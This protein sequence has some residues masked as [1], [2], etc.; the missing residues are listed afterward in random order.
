MT[1]KEYKDNR[2]SEFNKLPIFFAYSDEQ[3]ARA[4][5]ARGLTAADTDQVY[6]CGQAL[7]LKKDAEAVRA[8]LKRDLDAELREMMKSDPAFAEDAFYYEMGN[9]EYFINWQ[10]SW[11]V[12]SCFGSVEYGDGKG[13]RDYLAELGF[14][15]EVM[16]AYECAKTKLWKYWEEHDMF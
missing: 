15:E 12:C 4:M 5:E 13:Y 14:G 9:H 16:Q 1:Y 6:R 10:A 3:F 8:W 11:D 7:Y 2:Q